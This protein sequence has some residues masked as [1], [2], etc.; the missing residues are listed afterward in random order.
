M[1]LW[2]QGKNI[3][4]IAES[5][6]LKEE[7]IFSHI[8]KLVEKRKINRVDLRRLKTKEL[9]QAQ[10]RIESIFKKLG[11]DKLA[12]VFERLG[13]EYSYNLLR[14]ARLFYVEDY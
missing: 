14:L 3:E 7:T 5:R 13:G 10:S 6:G 11:K 8:E 2:N 12:V 9:E 4:Q 1:V